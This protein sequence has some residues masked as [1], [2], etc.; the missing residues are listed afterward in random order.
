MERVQTC[1][2]NMTYL[3]SIRELTGKS[4]CRVRGRGERSRDA[5][6]AGADA[7]LCTPLSSRCPRLSK[8]LVRER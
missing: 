7:L 2:S 6:G 1:S 3:Y 4:T 5:C 8:P